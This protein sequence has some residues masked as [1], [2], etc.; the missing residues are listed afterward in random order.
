MV[1]EERKKEIVQRMSEISQLLS[2]SEIQ[3]TG[4]EA[5]SAEMEALRKELDS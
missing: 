4:D 5:L 2:S 1:T 3:R